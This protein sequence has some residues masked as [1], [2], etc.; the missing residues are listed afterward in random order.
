MEKILSGQV[1]KQNGG[2][3]IISVGD[4]EIEAVGAVRLGE[5]VVL[6]IRPEN[7][8]LSVSLSQEGTSARNVFRGRIVKIVSMGV[9]QKVQL[10]CGFPL[11]ANVTNH[12]LSELSLTEGKYVSA[13]FKATA[14]RVIRKGE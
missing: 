12:S 14:V 5:S 7:I 1:I 9:Y 3:F 11:V 6:C 8:T 13:S 4:H 2:T 10:D